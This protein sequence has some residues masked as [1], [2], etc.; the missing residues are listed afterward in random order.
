MT[1]PGDLVRATTVLA[2]IREGAIAMAS[3]GQ[4]TS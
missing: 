1:R 3:D 2:V 4:V